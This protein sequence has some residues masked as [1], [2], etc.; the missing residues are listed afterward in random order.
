MCCLCLLFWFSLQFCILLLF[1]FSAP[2]SALPICSYTQVCCSRF[3][4]L[5][6]TRPY[7]YV[8]THRFAALLSKCSEL[9]TVCLYSSLLLKYNHLN[10]HFSL[11]FW[12]I[13]VAE[14]LF[15]FIFFVY[16]FA[17]LSF[18]FAFANTLYLVLLLSSIY[19][20]LLWGN[21]CAPLL[22]CFILVRGFGFVVAFY[23]VLCLCKTIHNLIVCSI[24]CM[25][26]SMLYSF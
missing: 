9:P 10:I 3:C 22:F 13:S 25:Q 24:T 11:W 16:I 18:F 21:F 19:L 2:Y 5:L 20:V 26:K 17:L 12:P 23:F 6:P 1:S 4:F 14:M 15:C 7:L 8:H